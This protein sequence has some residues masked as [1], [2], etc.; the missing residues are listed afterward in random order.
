MV[1]VGD[2]NREQTPDPDRLRREL[3]AERAAAEHWRDV[4]RRREAA[5]ADLKG[6]T[7]I[8]AL[9]ALERRSAPARS[10]ARRAV[11]SAREA[12][13]RVALTAAALPAKGAATRRRRDLDDALGRASRP[14]PEVG[15]ARTV[16]LVALGSD[17]ISDR[18]LGEAGPGVR[19]VEATDLSEAADLVRRAPE[20]LICL[21]S[22]SVEPLTEGWLRRL[23][24]VV[25]GDVL[26]A[27]AVLVHPSRPTRS[28]TPHDLLVRSAGLAVRPDG[29]SSV[30]IEAC[31]AGRGVSEVTGPDRTARPGSEVDVG[32][33]PDP[34]CP[35]LAH[36]AVVLDAS[37]LRLSG[38]LRPASSPDVAIVDLSLRLL[39]TSPA[40]RLTATP[41]VLAFDHRPVRGAADLIG[42]F[43]DR[44]DGWTALLADH[45]SALRRLAHADR[46]RQLDVVI[47]VA[48][49]S[50]KVAE[51]WGDWHLAEGLA[52]AL[53]RSGHRARVQT[54]A[55]ADSDAS[56]LADLHLVLRGLARVPRVDGQRHAL[57]IIS[58]PEDL[59]PEEIDAADVVFVASEAYAQALRAQTSTPVV[60]LLQATDPDRFKPV[61]PVPRH[62]HP[63]TVVGR[64]RDVLRPMVRD[65]VSIGLRPAIYGSGWTGLVDP[66]LIIADHVANSDLPAVYSSAGVVLNDH[67]GTMR[68]WGF[69]SNRVFDV[70]A[71]GTPLASDHMPEITELFGDLVPTWETPEELGEVVAALQAD[72]DPARSRA[73]RAREIVLQG[74]TFD[75]RAAV[76]LAALDAPTTGHGDLAPRSRAPS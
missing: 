35:L 44:D 5:L 71:C 30:R 8:R 29:G 42:P 65:A 12:S 6:R 73:A 69:V 46:S 47:T 11:S 50:A 58:H 7:S 24:A 56:R 60:V 36:G 23:A 57:W 9:L 1:A 2:A 25:S 18:V 62:V 19:L 32:A 61:P 74:H 53:G 20:D 40:A 70:L 54:L 17:R 49:P 55:D 37:A 48:S 22:P 4:A 64:S 31:A 59:D 43:S 45:G 67:W 27:C 63:L 39:R 68:R 13:A 15:P 21:L 16:L 38:G 52:R 26:G 34:S 66:E 41:E 75:H 10:R 51:H 33:P 3:A 28:A 14:S 72:P 76:L